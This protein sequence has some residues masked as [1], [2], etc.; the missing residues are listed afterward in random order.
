VGT[1]AGLL[2][3]AVANVDY[4]IASIESGENAYAIAYADG[5][6]H[7]LAN[8][9]ETLNPGD[10][11]SNVE[12]RLNGTNLSL[13]VDGVQKVSTTSSYNQAET[14]VGLYGYNE[15]GNGKVDNFTVVAN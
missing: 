13:W 12:F 1:Y 14:K 8:S 11:L 2:A 4:V 15:D 9:G 3:R 5:S 10:V 7:E 6:Y